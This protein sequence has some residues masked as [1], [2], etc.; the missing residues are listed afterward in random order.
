[1]LEYVFTSVLTPVQRA[2]DELGLQIMLVGGYFT[3][4]VSMV[5]FNINEAT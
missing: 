3:A 2:A 4:P 5:F 1:M